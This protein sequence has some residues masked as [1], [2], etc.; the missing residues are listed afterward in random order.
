[1][2]IQE[3]K[4]RN[5]STV[6]ALFIIVGCASTP[7]TDRFEQDNAESQIDASIQQQWNSGSFTASSEYHFTLA[8]AY[9]NEGKT[10]LAIEEYK[11]ALAYDN[12]SA[13]LHAKLAAEYLKKGQASFAIEESKEAIKLD[14]RYVDARLML[15]GIYSLNSAFDEALVEYDEVLKIEPTNDEAAVFKTQ[16]LVESGNTEKAVEFIRKFVS[17]SEESA[18]AWF[19]LGKLE[20]ISENQ[21]AAV[22]AFRKALGLRPGFTQATLALGMLFELNGENKK[23]L[24]V[25][26]AQLEQKQD[27]QVAGRLATLYLKL[28]Q[29]DFALST[30]DLMQA[31]D[32]DDLNVQMKMGLVHLQKQ[33]WPVA[34]LKFKE[35]LKKV[36]DSDK[37]HYYIALAHQ[38][39]GDWE[40]AVYHWEQVSVDSKMFEDA[41]LQA[42]E[43][44][45]KGFKKDKAYELLESALGRSPENPA[46]YLALAS[47][48]EDDHKP[49]AAGDWL[50][51]GLKHFPDHEKLRYFYGAILEKMGKS[52]DAVAQ[53]ERLLKVN[54]NHA[55]ALNFVA[56]TWTTQGVKLK[57]AESMLKRAIALKPESPF[58]L[59][60]MGWNLFVLGKYKEALVYLEK[61]ASLKSDEPAILEHLVEVYTR[62]EMFERAASLKSKINNML[63]GR[64]PASANIS[65]DRSDL[66]K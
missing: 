24:E 39:S 31:L 11:A 66:K 17:K 48:Y 5:G 47:L 6:L 3:K 12:G 19:Y 59:D 45:V 32:P 46:L 26:Q 51:K 52:E 42:A 41:N 40:A 22:R 36:P 27:Y 18:A 20:Q 4:I 57:E 1:M 50:A 58:I 55:D 49:N 53:M 2:K 8:Q 15:G 34:K 7:K 13:I 61:A 63:G 54:P 23:A 43:A 62:N 38:E 64:A 35:I 33:D 16:V 29:Y 10:D 21:A 14:P 44:L 56:Y 65:G 25:Y 37:A 60:S 30:L 9:S 28:N